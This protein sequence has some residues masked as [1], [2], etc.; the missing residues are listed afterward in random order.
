MSK[1]N[2]IIIVLGGV[3]LLAA[4]LGVFARV[5]GGFGDPVFTDE[6]S[7][8]RPIRLDHRRL[9]AFS[10]K[11]ID[12]I[13]ETLMTTASENETPDTPAEAPAPPLLA[14]LPDAPLPFPKD[15]VPRDED[16]LKKFVV[17]MQQD[18][19][20]EPSPAEQWQFNLALAALKVDPAKIPEVIR[21]D[22]HPVAESETFPVRL[23]ARESAL[24]GPFALGH[25][26]GEDGLGIVAGGGSALF[27]IIAE[28][29]LKPHDGLSAVA[30]GNGVYPAD[31]DGD[32][33]LALFITR[34]NGLPNSLLRNEGEGKFE[35][36]T[37]AL[38]LLSF[39]DT[40]SAAWLDYDGDGFLDLLVGSSDH[41]LELYHQTSGGTFQPIAWDLGLWVP[42]GVHSI[43]V[44]DF[45]G[46]GSP[47]FFLGISG[48]ADRL[49]LAKP[50]PTREAWR[51]EN[52]ATASAADGDGSAS[53]VFF[54]FDNDGKPDLLLTP[55]PATPPGGLHL[56]R[57]EGGGR[58]ADVTA[59]AG[60]EG[61]T[62]TTAAGVADLDNDSYEDLILGTGPLAINRVF[63][64]REGAGFKEV[65]IVSQGSYLDEPVAFTTADLEG[66]GTVDI[67]S[68]DRSGT[69]R[70]L[71]ASGARDHWITLKVR[72]A[73]AG[74]RVTL[75]VRDRD[76]VLHE[77]E[78][79]P[80]TD[81]TIMIGIGEAD[82]IERITVLGPEGGEALHTV[83]KVTLDQELAL[84]LPKQPRKR[85]V[86]P[87]KEQNGA[88]ESPS[89]E[90][91]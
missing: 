24:F 10:G 86:V 2:L 18:K 62:G 43:A 40:T 38:G 85:A 64:N 72:N 30:P 49:C 29:G 41:P 14:M 26:L 1:R 84:D 63:W 15:A 57:N 46:D 75:S 58:F 53:G 22:T 78:R 74:F 9:E 13:I 70:W 45:S 60:L 7:A 27:S 51:F 67:L 82:V 42:R 81:A 88:A 66:N 76:W 33:D 6:I 35:D 69:V 16:G 32:G 4:A 44:S 28:G 56:L 21:L 55:S 37:I 89:S 20:G 19:E 11:S 80:G 25:F 12:E 65:T 52:V 77:I 61:L 5:R 8:K 83:E 59:E 36:V 91:K 3:A 39:N 17:G 73:P 90:P 54:D 87:I 23:V 50:S 31:F 47:D 79:R 68:R 34:A 71:E 48:A